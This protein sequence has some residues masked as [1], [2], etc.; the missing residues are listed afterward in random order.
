[1][2]ENRTDALCRCASEPLPLN[3]QVEVR[4]LRGLS[5]AG[6]KAGV[7]LSRLRGQ[8][9]LLKSVASRLKPFLFVVRTLPVFVRECGRMVWSRLRHRVYVAPGDRAGRGLAVTRAART[10]ICYRGH[11]GR[12]GSVV[13]FPG[14]GTAYI[15]GRG[16]N[17]VKA[18]K[19][20]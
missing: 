15:V 11:P 18:G 16:G 2:S 12:F 7:R 19:K 3:K 5:G 14:T 13:R 9:V 1:M 6:E 4:F 17:L 8:P 10:G 20:R